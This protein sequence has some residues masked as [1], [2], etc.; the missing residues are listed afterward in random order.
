MSTF[1]AGGTRT[2]WDR[3]VDWFLRDMHATWGLAIA[4]IVFGVFTLALVVEDWGLRQFLWGPGSAWSQ[5]YRDETIWTSPIFGFFD[6]SD[7]EWIFTAKL[8]V[9]AVAG[10]TMTIGLFS[11]ASTIVVFLLMTSLIALGPTS[12][13]SEDIVFRILTLWLCFADTSQ[14]LSLDRWWAARRGRLVDIGG[15]RPARRGLVPT[16]VRVP[17]H[18]AA[19]VLIMG[20]LIVIYV[21][22][23]LAKLTGATWRNGTAVYYPFHVEFL[24]PWPELTH[25]LGGFTPM[26]LVASWGSV[27]I[28]LLFPLLLL[29][30]H[31][32][33]FVVIAL[34]MLHVGIAVTLG[35]GLFS[36]AMCGADLAFVRDESVERI[37]AR[38]RDLRGRAKPSRRRPYE[39]SVPGDDESVPLGRSRRHL[40][41][42]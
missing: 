1:A 6:A 21:V 36:L 14:R 2:R 31:T 15:L 3:V 26:V 27:A 10:F 13:D 32:R 20:Q 39:A 28:Q 12:T 17:V 7:T 29:Q 38:W 24:S 35:L 40:R 8:L 18:N 23:G 9:L 25:A 41:G 33:I 22:A 4:R 42:T 34:V 19:L 5:P 30:R 16:W 37:K 11:R